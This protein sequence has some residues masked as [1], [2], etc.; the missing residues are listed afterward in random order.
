MLSVHEAK[1][2]RDAA[3]A[4]VRT[5]IS[6]GQVSLARVLGCKVMRLTRLTENFAQSSLGAE[7]YMLDVPGD[8]ISGFRED[9]ATHVV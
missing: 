7:Y 2:L 1:G 6:E 9:A 8:E 5:A 3:V 4:D